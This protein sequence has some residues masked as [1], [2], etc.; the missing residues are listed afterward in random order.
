MLAVEKD[1]LL[2]ATNQHITTIRE[3]EL[4][5]YVNHLGNMETIATLIAGFSFTALVKMDTRL[6]MDTLL[7]TL[8]SGVE[9]QH[10]PDDRGV[11]VT[12]IVRR[13]FVAIELFAFFMQ[14]G[15]LVA[16]VM[17]LGEM[18]L[19]ITESLLSRLLG[20][21]LALRG[22]DGSIIRASRHLA[23]TLSSNTRRFF[24]GLQFF[25]MAI[26]FHVLRA[27]HPAVSGL[28]IIILI[29]Y[30]RG[31]GA[32]AEKSANVY[33]LSTGVN[34]AFDRN[35]SDVVSQ[36]S[37]AQQDAYLQDQSSMLESGGFAISPSAASAPNTERDSSPLPEA[38]SGTSTAQSYTSSTA[39]GTP[40]GSAPGPAPPE[41]PS[42]SRWNRM[43]MWLLPYVNPV[44][45]RLYVLSAEV[46]D[47][48]EEGK[49]GYRP[50]RVAAAATEH[51]IHHTET[52]QT[53]HL[54]GNDPSQTLFSPRLGAVIQHAIRIGGSFT[55][56]F[57][58]ASSSPDMS[59]EWQRGP[60]AATPQGT[61]MIEAASSARNQ[62]TPPGRGLRLPFHTAGSTADPTSAQSL[63]TPTAHDGFAPSASPSRPYHA[64]SAD[65][66][67][68]MHQA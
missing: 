5:Y 65:A 37:A 38:V 18:L 53:E 42:G 67:S 66:E 54:F 61:A 10:L 20:T 4:L 11:S 57:F 22:P 25:M 30:W 8:P 50:H 39:M 32:M 19:V 40:E 49:I 59:L 45:H 27:Q 64:S 16:V 68:N 15:E 51:M 1:N 33:R 24:N 2:A 14:V 3:K 46:D 52:K 28:V 9:E 63:T 35:A 21:R 47:F 44:G 6:D 13:E 58:S 12:S 60:S 62:E 17:T 31:Q 41:V 29:P 56:P 43:K 23:S 48:D 7:F 26:V 36:T 34:T 55:E